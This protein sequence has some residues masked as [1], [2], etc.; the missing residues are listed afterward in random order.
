MKKLMRSMTAA[1]FTATLGSTFDWVV[2]AADLPVRR[3]STA[4]DSPARD[5][6]ATGDLPKSTSDPAK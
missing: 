6:P 2:P 4:R 3:P 1:F 5:A